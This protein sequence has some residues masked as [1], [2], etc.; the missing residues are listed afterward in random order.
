MNVV[1]LVGNLTRDPEM[2]YTP[3]GKAVTEFTVA[4]NEGFGEKRTT[5]YIR[6]EAW[7]RLAESV[8]ERARK[9]SKV[10]V[11]GRI[12]VN[13][14]KDEKTNAKRETVRINCRSV[15]VVGAP[16]NIVPELAFTPPRPSSSRPA[17]QDDDDL[18]DLPF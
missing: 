14:W 3:G 9:G 17:P 6:C 15:S 1:L 13:S 18:D 16:E 12:K 2:R 7:E 10:A 5:E 8:A 4:V 11:E